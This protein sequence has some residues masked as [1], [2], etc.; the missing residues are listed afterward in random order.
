MFKTNNVL[1][2]TYREREFRLQDSVVYTGE[3]DLILV[4][5]G[6]VTDFASVPQFIQWLIPSYGKYTLAAI[7]HDYLCVQLNEYHA[8]P[9]NYRRGTGE[10]V[11][12]VPQINSRDTDGIFRR[13][14]REL[15]VP[16]VRRW[17]MWTGV[18]WGALFSDSR[19]K[20]IL[21]D[22]PLMVLWSI[23]ASPVVVP[24]SIFVGI[25]LLI[26]RAVEK[27]VGVFCRE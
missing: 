9:E 13:I 2:E 5:Q 19:R 7:V 14:M 16:P 11:S 22:L 21:P 1:L 27:V 8:D 18:R 17:L 20:G 4:P 10:I 25:G 15:G 24:A 26:D 3:H 6:F 12:V 23:I